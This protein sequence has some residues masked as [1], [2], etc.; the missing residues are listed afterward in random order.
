[1]LHRFVAMSFIVSAAFCALFVRHPETLAL[2]YLKVS[3]LRNDLRLSSLDNSSSKLHDVRS[4]S[5]G[6]S[7]GQLNDVRL[8][9][10][11]NSSSQL[12]DVRLSSLGNSSGQLNDLRSSSLGNSSSQLND[13]RLSSLG[14]SSSQ[15]KPCVFGEI[16]VQCPDDLPCCSDGRCGFSKSICLCRTCQILMNATAKS[17]YLDV[18]SKELQEHQKTMRNLSPPPLECLIDRISTWKRPWLMLIG[19]SN[20]RHLFLGLL[21]MMTKQ[22]KYTM[23]K[24]LPMTQNRQFD[25][26]WFDA[27]VL[28]EMN[29]GRFSS[30]TT[31]IARVSLRFMFNP[32]QRLA[33][34]SGM[35]HFPVIPMG[36]GKAPNLNK[37][38]NWT[39]YPISLPPRFAELDQFMQG[40]EVVIGTHGLWN[41]ATRANCQRAQLLAQH[42][43]QL[44]KSSVGA[45][46]PPTQLIWASN[47]PITANSH[48]NGADVDVDLRCQREVAKEYGLEVFDM[49]KFVSD[50]RVE[51]GDFHLSDNALKEVWK[52][53][54]SRLVPECL[55]W[56]KGPPF[57]RSL[58]IFRRKKKGFFT[59]FS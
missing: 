55:K 33:N 3:E 9:S 10:L 26:R 46:K 5:L 27:D 20:W 19:D 41:F 43:S 56:K 34:W 6:N 53:I 28:Y 38:I 54:V 21:D 49:E 35:G 16:H 57:K 18:V 25:D 51:I 15:L 22:T 47:F 50:P 42:L 31:G 59:L 17:K 14:N 13:V 2:S 52:A 24:H 12:N 7:S 37:N 1:M 8:T 39:C 32:L 23:Y 45:I 44:Q 36:C 29:H 58:P 48:F 11:G 40:P 4:S 30:A